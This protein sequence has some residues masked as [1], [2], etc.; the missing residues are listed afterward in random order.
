[1]NIFLLGFLMGMSHSLDADHLLGVGSMAKGDMSVKKITALGIF[2]GLG[3][4]ATLLLMTTLVVF[5]NILI[6]ERLS[7]VLE[8]V[9]GMMLIFLGIEVYRKIRY[10]RI[11][12]HVH[13]HSDN[14]IHWHAHSHNEL[15]TM[16]SPEHKHLIHDHGHA[17]NIKMP[18]SKCKS[19]FIGLLHGGAGASAVLAL[20]FVMTEDNFTK[21]L[22]VLFFGIGSLIGMACVTFSLSWPL[23][24]MKHL[25]DQKINRIYSYFNYGLAIVTIAFGIFIVI[26]SG[27][28]A[29]FELVNA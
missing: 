28:Q 27:Y 16:T 10:K 4:T 13:R 14:V 8:T 24:K 26:Y 3:H 25:S 22:Y 11:H 1:M 12:F 17:E 29:M 19:F 2:W 15:A 9:V 20:V 21:L 6:S 23:R 7:L 18:R 5:F